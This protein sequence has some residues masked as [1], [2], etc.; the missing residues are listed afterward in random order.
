MEYG[1]IFNIP[2]SDGRDAMIYAV[3]NNNEHAV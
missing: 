3:C 2:D 1:A